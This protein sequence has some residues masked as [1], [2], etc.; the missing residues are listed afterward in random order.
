M[1]AH[2][3]LCDRCAERFDDDAL[4]Y[5][6]DSNSYLCSEC[7]TAELEE[8]NLFDIDEQL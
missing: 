6:E 4:E 8:D 7:I 1:D 3:M 2:T 5:I